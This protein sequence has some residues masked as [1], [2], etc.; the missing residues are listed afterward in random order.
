M[1]LSKEISFSQQK[2]SIRSSIDHQKI[3]EKKNGRSFISALAF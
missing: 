1:I 2:I 3:K